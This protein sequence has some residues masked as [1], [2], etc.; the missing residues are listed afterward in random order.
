MVTPLSLEDIFHQIAQERGSPIDFDVFYNPFQQEFSFSAGERWS[1]FPYPFACYTHY[2]SYADSPELSVLVRPSDAA[3]RFA[4]KGENL[5]RFSLGFTFGD[6][7]AVSS[8]HSSSHVMVAL[9]PTSISQLGELGYILLRSYERTCPYIVR[10]LR[11]GGTQDVHQFISIG[12][13]KPMIY[14][15]ADVVDTSSSPF[16][17]S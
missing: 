7:A 2:T 3:C 9:E 4:K 8:P 11:R 15:F 10:M 13:V 14:A 17:V 6:F 12:L 1:N 5:H 16:D